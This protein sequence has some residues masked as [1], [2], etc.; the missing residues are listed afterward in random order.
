V[1]HFYDVTLSAKKPQ[2]KAYPKSLK[3]IGDH[4]RKRRLDL[5][6]CQKDDA[7]I[8]GFATD[9]ITIWEKDRVGPTL[10][11]IPKVIEFLGYDPF[12]NTA[13][14]VGEKIRQYRRYKGL[15]I[16]K[17]ARDLGVDP[18]NLAGWERGKI[19]PKGKL[20]ERVN[21]F[22]RNLTK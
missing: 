7:K 16:K 15:S 6:L 12:S 4:L 10:R 11:F 13:K 19:E 5:K 21:L 14:S 17:L 20:K 1:L 8:I 3:T 18:T 22:L 9:T 2:D